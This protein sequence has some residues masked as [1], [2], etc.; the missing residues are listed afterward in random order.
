MQQ[1]LQVLPQRLCFKTSLEIPIAWNHL[2][3]TD[4]PLNDF[5]S[6][7]PT[8]SL[9]YNLKRIHMCP[10]SCTQSHYSTEHS[11]A[12]RRFFLQKDRGI[13]WRLSHSGTLSL[14]FPHTHTDSITTQKANISSAVCGHTRKSP[15]SRFLLVFEEENAPK[16]TETGSDP[17]G[18]NYSSS[19]WTHYRGGE[20]PS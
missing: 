5:A 17:S 7:L 15:K 11:S 12:F 1:H 2:R 9:I 13:W 20:S 16:Q 8:A 3:T 14:A 10:A 19:P 18:P 6:T 4:Q